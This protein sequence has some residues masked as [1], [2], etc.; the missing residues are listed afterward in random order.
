MNLSTFNV[1]L[2]NYP[3]TEFQ[4]FIFPEILLD[5]DGMFLVIDCQQIPALNMRVQMEQIATEAHWKVCPRPQG[6]Y[7]DPIA[8]GLE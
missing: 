3:R 4:A 6:Q 2:Q 7:P 5:V 1:W 8:V